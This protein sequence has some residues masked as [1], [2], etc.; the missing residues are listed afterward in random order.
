MSLSALLT[1][2]SVHDSQVAIA[3]AMMTARRVT[4]L[5]DLMDA[6]LDARKNHQMRK[7]LGHVPIIDI[8]PRREKDLK[9]ERDQSGSAASRTISAGAMPVSRG[10]RRSSAIRCSVSSN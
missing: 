9:E 6:A 7:Q 10:T 2:A 4:N 3:V 8:C 1:S 5:V